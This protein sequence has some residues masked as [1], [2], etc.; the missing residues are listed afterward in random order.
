[1]FVV[2]LLQVAGLFQD[3][4]IGNAINIAVVRLI[5]LEKDEVMHFS[6]F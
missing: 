5:L 3:A 4:S 1:M 2:F 6:V